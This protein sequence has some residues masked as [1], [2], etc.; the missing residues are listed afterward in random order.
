MVESVV[1]NLGIA[2]ALFSLTLA[3]SASAQDL[4]G[5]GIVV[6]PISDG[7]NGSSYF[8]YLIVQRGLEALGYTVE[9]QQ[10]ANYPTVH[11]AVANG[12]SD[13][14][15][16]HWQPLHNAFFENAGGEK[17][18]SR[19]GTLTPNMKQGYLIDKR[20][21]ET[22]GI[23]NIGQLSDPKLAAVFDS[24][25]DGKAN[26]VGCNPGWG[27][28]RIIE[29][30]MTAYKLS[31]TIHHDQGE[32][33]ALVADMLERY[34][35]GQSILYYTWSPFWLSSVLKPGTDVIWLNVPFS[36]SPDDPNANTEAADGTNTGFALSTI[37]V[38]A[39]NKFLDENPAARKFFEVATIPLADSE[40][41][42]NIIQNGE[43]SP[44][45]I[46]RHA[47]EW[48]QANRTTFDGWV[49]EALKAAQP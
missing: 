30:H 6:Q 9:E 21:A 44:E 19:V 37:R 28:E 8:R 12:D 43:S 10:E 15:P 42:E 13:Y 3:P 38:V 17:V 16:V 48:I 1:R 33:V 18:M 47:S 22:Y 20:A 5:K 31:D 7:D 35:K 45:D 36:A 2:V 11:L 29:N 40:A 46:E 32:Y 27:C 39:N 34:K 23:S 24:D 25:G 26:L 4:P 14:T 41:E 49:S